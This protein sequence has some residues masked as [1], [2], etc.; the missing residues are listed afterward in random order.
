MR[1]KGSSRMSTEISISTV[2]LVLKQSESGKKIRR[3]VAKEQSTCSR[4]A[5]ARS[6]LI[7]KKMKAAAQ[8]IINKATKSSRPILRVASISACEQ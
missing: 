2:D 1:R 5:S 7:F 6:A 4:G 3:G 8:F